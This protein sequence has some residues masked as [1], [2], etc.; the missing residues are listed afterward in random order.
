MRDIFFFSVSRDIT[1]TTPG[2]TPGFLFS[3]TVKLG[4]RINRE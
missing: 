4:G 1:V 3:E 2:A